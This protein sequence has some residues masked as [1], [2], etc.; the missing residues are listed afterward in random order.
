VGA[1]AFSFSAYHFMHLLGHL[2]LVATFW[3]PWFALLFLGLARGDKRSSVTR[4][5]LVLAGTAY[6][7]WHY[8]L[9]EILFAAVIIVHTRFR[10]RAEAGQVLRRTAGVLAL[11]ALF[12]SP[13]LVPMLA[14]GPEAGRV[15]DPRGDTMR[16]SA[17]LLGF[18]T[19]STLHTVWG[20]A[21]RSL[22]DRLAGDGN[23]VES[24]V[25]LGA[26]ALLLAFA[27][28][29]AQRRH[30]GET[31]TAHADL[32]S[33]WWWVF[34]TFAV[35]ALGPVL[36]V[37][38]VPVTVAGHEIPLPGALL[39]YLPYGDVPRTPARFVVMSILAVS[40]LA[41]Q[42][43]A[44]LM[45]RIPPRR[46]SMLGLLIAGCVLLDN[47]AVPLPT[48]P[49][50][51][52]AGYR[53]LA[54]RCGPVDGA[55]GGQ[56]ILELPIPD[57]PFAYRQRM[58]YQTVHGCAVFGGFVARGLPPLP[59]SAIP[60]FAQLRSLTD[61]VDDV[62]RYDKASLRA[63]SLGALAAYE[64]GYV[65]IDKRI[66]STEEVARARKVGVGLA[67]EDP[68][69]FEDRDTL[70]YAVPQGPGPSAPTLWLDRG[71][72]YL[73]RANDG[74][75]SRWRWMA[76]ESAIRLSVPAAGSYSL[77]LEAGAL[78][79]PRGLA[80]SVDGVENRRVVVDPEKGSISLG[81]SLTPGL[82]LVTLRSIG[83]ADVP[84]NGD[85]RRLSV[86]LHDARI[87]AEDRS[88]S[89]SSDR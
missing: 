34:L 23:V 43:T 16:F 79:R 64:T 15:T 27:S 19:P 17:D 21:L 76:E 47:W 2:D 40:V 75:E 88:I 59:L 12:V 73:E 11:W 3:L 8:A 5:A 26:A 13:L 39:A 37:G 28:R 70:I 78:G 25:Y 61:E 42:G 71:W 68:P 36:R 49:I 86:A 87:T 72:S 44:R 53:W 63:V 24:T 58:L 33:L 66:L 65:V 46:R 51:V 22:N 81:L 48:M 83:G 29:L 57:D 82:H 14:K 10:H 32:T 67:G 55:P 56:A 60:G 69:A 85:R 54:S 84:G 80:V 6:T 52:P 38:G 89:I 74:S 18:L 20:P 62:I 1:C 31:P 9:D 30:D 35:L 4:T 77:E 7:S 41:A 50:A 45:E